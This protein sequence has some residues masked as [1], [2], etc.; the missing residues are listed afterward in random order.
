MDNPSS[1]IETLAEAL[2][3]YSKANNQEMEDQVKL[4]TEEVKNMK[5][6]FDEIELFLVGILT[7]VVFRGGYSEDEDL[8]DEDLED[9]DE[10]L[11]EDDR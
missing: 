4:L 8:E 3:A 6:K 7:D 2:R 5:K 11:E 1:Q 9:D 10:Y